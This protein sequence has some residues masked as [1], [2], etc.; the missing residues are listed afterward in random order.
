MSELVD[1]K[2]QQVNVS[3][4][5]NIETAI[6]SEINRSAR[7]SIDSTTQGQRV[8]DYEGIMNIQRDVTLLS[9]LNESTNADKYIVRLLDAERL[10]LAGNLKSVRRD[11]QRLSIDLMNNSYRRNYYTIAIR[12]TWI[13][14]IITLGVFAIAAAWRLVWIGPVTASVIL[15]IATLTYLAICIYWMN[16]LKFSR[17]RYLG[18]EV[19]GVN[20]SSMRSA[21]GLPA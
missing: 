6:V 12:L 21:I 20:S 18:D 2:I 4:N 7:N 11:Q 19:W 8:S 3:T 15:I 16:K 14:M 9:A 10:R 13:T 17:G 1:A 5:D